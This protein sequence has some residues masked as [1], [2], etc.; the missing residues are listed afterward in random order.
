VK[1]WL[2]EGNDVKLM[3]GVGGRRTLLVCSTASEFNGPFVIQYR[4][5]VLWRLLSD[6]FGKLLLS[7]KT[8]CWCSKKFNLVLAV[9]GFYPYHL[10]SQQRCKQTFR[11]LSTEQ[12]FCGFASLIIDHV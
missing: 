11:I 7:N 5:F 4:L 8:G 1:D 10:Q 6:V 9:F 12:V 2:C 3:A